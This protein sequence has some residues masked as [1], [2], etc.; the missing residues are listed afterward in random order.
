M[1]AQS[2]VET[3]EMIAWGLIWVLIPFGS[4]FEPEP[5]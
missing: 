5:L 2:S 3:L 4:Q 1:E